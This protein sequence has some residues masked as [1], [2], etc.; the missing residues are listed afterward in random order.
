MIMIE[1][2]DAINAHQAGDA[3]SV[4]ISAVLSAC[5]PLVGAAFGEL[6][7]PS[8]GAPGVATGSCR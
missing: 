5:L 7:F 6:S 2:S 8:P 4:F 1:Q 3:V